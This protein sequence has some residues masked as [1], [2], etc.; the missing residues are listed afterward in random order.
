MAIMKAVRYHGPNEKLT[1]DDVPVPSDLGDEDVLVQ[2]HAAALCHTELHFCDGTLNLGVEPMTLGHEACG[3]ITQVGDKVDKS[4]IGQRVIVYYYVGCQ[5]CKW[6]QQ[7]DEQLCDALKA[8]FGFISDGGLAEYM[9][10]PARNAI[11]LPDNLS[12]VSAAPIGCGVTTAVHASKLARV[13]KNETALIYGVN[14]VGFGLLQLLKNHYGVSKVIC[15][16]RS[17]SKKNLCIELGADQ[18]LDGTDAST[19]AAAVRECTDG[20]GVDVIFECVGRRETMDACVGWAGALG[21]RGR[22]VMIGYH[23]GDEHEFRYHPMPMIVYEQQILGSVGATLEDL[24]EAVEFVEQG[25]VKTIVDRKVPLTDYQSG[26][27]AIRE[28]QCCGKIVC[29]PCSESS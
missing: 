8:E 11:V 21:K 10:A 18:V 27:D 13:Q 5:Q 20:K 7:G 26:L 15:V 6:C 9:K 17:E 1:L 4:R 3:V 14:G 25:K 28:N 29:L 12:F 23:A 2:V 16:A 19:V 24:E 22:L